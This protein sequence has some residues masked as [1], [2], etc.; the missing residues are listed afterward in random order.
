MAS[1]P[2]RHNWS[3]SDNPLILDKDRLIQMYIRE[4]FNRTQKIFEWSG[5]PD[6]IPAKDL[7][8]ILQWGGFAIIVENKGKN[9]T[10]PDGQLYA[11]YGGLGGKMDPY[12]L[13]LHA[14]L[15]NPWLKYTGD[16]EIG[17]DAEQIL[18]DSQ[19]LGLMP[20]NEKYASL[21]A[22]TDLSLR[23]ATINSRIIKLIKAGDDSTK[24]SA[25]EYLRQVE[26]GDHLGVIGGDDFFD[27]FKTEDYSS[28]AD[29]T[30]IKE[31]IELQQYLKSQWFIELGL[32]SNYNMKREAINSAES[33][34]NDDILMPLI[35]EM[36]EQRLLG[37]ERV[38]KMFGVNW[39]VKLASSWKQESESTEDK[40]EED[41]ENPD[42]GSDAG[43]APVS[44]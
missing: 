30:H 37:C 42:Q 27:Q 40:E 41:E 26:R 23:I 36:L 15:A 44:E 7:E 17:V 9:A 2:N 19:Y 20:I 1:V 5:L 21:L 11:L 6:S 38:N 39:S 12:Y 8:F 24:E 31:L 43:P 22:E 35:D 16:V 4:M 33:G 10:S 32:N 25:L 18:N 13:P 3:L 34:M 28:G 14:Q 29:G